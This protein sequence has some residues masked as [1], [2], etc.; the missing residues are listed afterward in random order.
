MLSH[1]YY[2]K[3][4][5]KAKHQSSVQHNLVRA[6]H[7]AAEKLRNELRPYNFFLKLLI[8]DHVHSLTAGAADKVVKLWLLGFFIVIPLISILIATSAGY[9]A[10]RAGFD[11]KT[12]F[13]SYLFAIYM[14]LTP[15]GILPFYALQPNKPSTNLLLSPLGFSL[16]WCYEQ[17]HES[18]LVEWSKVARASVWQPLHLKERH[19]N[20]GKHIVLELDSQDFSFAEQLAFR[21]ATN[22]N[23]SLLVF[24]GRRIK[25]HLSLD[26]FTR[27]SDRQTF[28]YNLCRNLSPDQLDNSLIEENKI[29]L[30]GHGDGEQ[31]IRIQGGSAKAP[32]YTNMW[33]DDVHSARRRS[34][35]PL[36]TGQKL[37]DGRYVIRE[38]LA[39]GGQAV[40]YRARDDRSQADQSVVLKEFILPVSAG[41]QVRNRSFENVKNEADVL[42]S[43]DHPGIVKILDYF[44]EDHRAYLVL[45]SVAGTTVRDLVTSSGALGDDRVG[46]LLR[47][48]CDI[49]QYLHDRQPPIVHRDISPDNLM[50]TADGTIKLLD[51]NVAQRMESNE[52]KTVVGKHNYIAPEQ[53]RGK[54]VPQSD[55]YSLGG[56]I[57][58]MLTG[59]DPVPLSCSRPSTK[60][61]KSSFENLV[62]EMTQTSLEK[63]FKSV[64][65]VIDAC[66]LDDNTARTKTNANSH[67][68][69]GSSNEES[70]KN[71][72]DSKESITLTS[73]EKHTA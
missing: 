50:L 39:T 15:M 40:V 27:E 52:T 59:E 22:S 8:N 14:I 18:P 61:V 36:K 28:I 6:E 72:S 48:L 10:E 43:L 16:Q 60:G 29:M 44:V 41:S 55:L 19:S 58:F 47:C 5:L 2:Q 26:A 70:D 20:V 33:L 17:F 1:D 68:C 46:P 9:D 32:T 49:L 69:A 73:S 13:S 62:A 65:E 30:E 51:F 11:P 63:R 56:T 64:G 53:F 66:N 25:I 71:E 37:Q 21:N 45:E 24:P 42:S 67:E 23:R 54:P 31:E 4:E 3:V 57:F 34:V 38:K 7:V 12:V 35:E